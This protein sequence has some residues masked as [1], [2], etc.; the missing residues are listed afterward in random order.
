[1]VRA[2][3]VH[4]SAASRPRGP[5]EPTFVRLVTSSEIHAVINGAGRGR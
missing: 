2:R 4:S 3:Q 5:A 1:M